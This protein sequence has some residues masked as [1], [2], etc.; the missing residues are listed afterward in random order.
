MDTDLPIQ[1][2]RPFNFP[3][4]AEMLEKTQQVQTEVIES[5]KN[6][7]ITQLHQHVLNEMDRKSNKG[8]SR[9]IISFQYDIPV[10][11][12]KYNFHSKINTSTM[13][14]EIYNTYNPLKYEISDFAFSFKT[15]SNDI[16]S[17]IC[18]IGF[19]IDWKLKCSKLDTTIPNIYNLPTAFEMM[20]QTKIQTKVIENAYDHVIED[21]HL[22]VLQKINES[23]ELGFNA[24]HIKFEYVVPLLNS[25]LYNL[26][27]GQNKIENKLRNFYE[28][29]HGY[30]LREIR[31]NNTKNQISLNIE[32]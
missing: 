21:L 4:A 24:T 19:K 18:S 7:M 17:F 30:K 9:C 23:S 15:T 27:F 5:I 13:F 3:N 1:K 14:S 26:R 22:E 11:G 10:E 28:K 8:F 6:E 2:K 16:P 32:W 20:E 25:E 12:K 29:Q 31:Y